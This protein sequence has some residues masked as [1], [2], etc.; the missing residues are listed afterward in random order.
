MNLV[1]RT[2]KVREKTDLGALGRTQAQPGHWGRLSGCFSK[3]KEI[4]E[5]TDFKGRERVNEREGYVLDYL[6][7]KRLELDL[8]V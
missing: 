6:F 3:I 8:H 4:R 2:S 5:K 1:C 7:L